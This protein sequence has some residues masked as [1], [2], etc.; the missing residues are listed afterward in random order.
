MSTPNPEP[1]RSCAMMRRRASPAARTTRTAPTVSR[2]PVA[3][4]GA[5]VPR[6]VPPNAGPV[7]GNGSCTSGEGGSERSTGR[8][9]EP[10]SE[11]VARYGHGP[12]DLGPGHCP[13]GP[14]GPGY[15]SGD[16]DG[17]LLR[18]FCV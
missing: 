2:V 17:S 6:P 18:P 3:R 12:L 15:L 1:G 9:A 4:D 8:P 7:T 5:P 10:P 13:V 11:L 16:P 14:R